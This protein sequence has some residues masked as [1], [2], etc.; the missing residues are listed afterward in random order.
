M[1]FPPSDVKMPKYA[2]QELEGGFGFASSDRKDEAEADDT[3]DEP[4]DGQGKSLQLS[5]SC[6]LQRRGAESVIS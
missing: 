6:S 2:Y 3:G 5:W 4:S 1:F